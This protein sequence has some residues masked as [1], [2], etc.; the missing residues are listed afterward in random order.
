MLDSTF[1]WRDLENF[2]S[3]A[4]APFIANFDAFVTQI[5]L[6]SIPTDKVNR[7]LNYFCAI[8][9]PSQQSEIGQNYLQKPG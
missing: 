4:A 6:S 1:E 7:F 8:F 5:H 9:Y 3:A 2:S